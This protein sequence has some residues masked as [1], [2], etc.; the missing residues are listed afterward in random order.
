MKEKAVKLSE[1]VWVK[2]TKR[3]QSDN[4]FTSFITFRLAP[5]RFLVSVSVWTCD[6][7]AD[8][9]FHPPLAR[10]LLLFVIEHDMYLEDFA[11]LLTQSST[12]VISRNQYRN[13]FDCQLWLLH[14]PGNWNRLARII[15]KHGLILCEVGRW[16]LQKAI[17]LVEG[18]CIMC[19]H[20]TFLCALGRRHPHYGI[21]KSQ[22]FLEFAIKFVRLL[23]FQSELMPELFY[24]NR[25]Q[26]TFL[27]N[28]QHITEHMII[29]A[30]P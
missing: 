26:V 16:L 5:E 6:A 14:W 4:R 30:M 1:A 8:G 11:F 3:W 21:S 23:A 9:N 24:G 25:F 10:C 29:F 18:R 28:I 17:S 19:F 2:T 13:L 12:L 22:K 15:N 27:V 20:K 7:G